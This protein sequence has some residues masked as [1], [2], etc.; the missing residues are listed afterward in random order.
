MGTMRS[1]TTAFCL[2]LLAL[3]GCQSQRHVADF[4]ENELFYVDLEWRTKAPGDRAAFVLPVVD[5][6]DT[7]QLPIAERGFPIRYGGDDFW[8]RPVAEMLGDVLARQF[9]ASALFTSVQD[10]A[11]H[12]ALLVRPVLQRFHNG[13]I[14]D[15]SG[16]RSFAEIALSIQVL[17][18]AGADGKRAVLHEQVYGTRQLT[19]N[20]INPTSSYLVV[21]RAL[22]QTMQKVLTGLDGSNVARSAVPIEVVVP[23]EASAVPIRR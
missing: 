6:R 5:A 13:A 9:A 8:E 22:R 2:S 18:P 7:A 14:E 4:A 19:Q 12:D 17:G 15:M 21:G 16:S 10:H 20:E 23:A 11:S 3:S 1:L